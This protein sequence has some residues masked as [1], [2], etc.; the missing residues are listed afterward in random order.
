MCVCVCVGVRWVIFVAVLFVTWYTI[1]CQISHALWHRNTHT[2]HTHT[3]SLSVGW[4]VYI[5]CC[6]SVCLLW[7]CV[8]VCMCVCLTLSGCFSA[9]CK[10]FIVFNT[11]QKEV[12]ALCVSVCVCVCVC[13]CFITF[14]LPIIG[15]ISNKVR[16][17]LFC[18]PSWWRCVCVC[19]LL[20]CTLTLKLNW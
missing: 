18:F 7:M 19:V 10:L 16:V 14:T 4:W 3:Q 13:V 8:C 9:D 2:T 11:E 20:N 15:F 17:S 12:I 6:C 5:V 1:S